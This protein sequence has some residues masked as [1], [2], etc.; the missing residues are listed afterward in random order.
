MIPRLFVF[1]ICCL[2][3]VSCGTTYSGLTSSH[4]LGAGEYL[5]AV[6]LVASGK[7]QHDYDRD[8]PDCRRIASLRQATAS[9]QAQESTASDAIAGGTVGALGGLAVGASKDYN[10]LGS[11][12][13]GAAL[14]AGVATV[15][16]AGQRGQYVSSETRSTLL[17]CLRGRGYSVLE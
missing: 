11:A 14:G 1:L 17:A 6:D 8:L 16:S 13:T 3:L 9:Q 15:A 7:T 4:G 12:A 2:F 10:R 5:P